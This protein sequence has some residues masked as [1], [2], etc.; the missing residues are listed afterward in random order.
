MQRPL[1]SVVVC[2]KNNLYLL[3]NPAHTGQYNTCYRPSSCNVVF[4]CSVWWIL[5]LSSFSTSVFTLSLK[6]N[7]LVD[8]EEEEEEE[9]GEE[10]G[11][12][13]LFK[14]NKKVQ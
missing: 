8:E 5:G 3:F 11:F 6:Q 1:I 9:A 10:V 14:A 13:G 2:S 12:Y 4:E 7:E